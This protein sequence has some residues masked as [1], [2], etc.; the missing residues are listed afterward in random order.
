M[1]FLAVI[2]G[3]MCALAVIGFFAAATAAEKQRQLEEAVPLKE[4]DYETR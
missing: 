3:A 2:G 4:S 1:I